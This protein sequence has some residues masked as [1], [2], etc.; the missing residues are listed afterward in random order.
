[1]TETGSVM[2]VAIGFNNSIAYCVLRTTSVQ[3]E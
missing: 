2:T 3:R 1:M